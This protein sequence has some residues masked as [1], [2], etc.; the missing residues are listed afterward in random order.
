[1]SD[2]ETAENGK[3]RASVN[4]LLVGGAFLAYCQDRGWIV[5]EGTGAGA[6]Y[7]VTAAGEEP[8]RE[9]GVGMARPG[10]DA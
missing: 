6:K 7:F 3:F 9:Y 5:R 2:S 10:E 4:P 8:L 1:L